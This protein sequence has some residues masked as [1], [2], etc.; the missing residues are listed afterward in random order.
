MFTTASLCMCTI[1]ASYVLQVLVTAACM[2]LLPIFFMSL[3]L[4]VVTDTVSQIIPTNGSWFSSSWTETHIR[5]FVLI[6]FYFS[7]FSL[8]M[9]KK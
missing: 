2:F 1:G 9:F 8:V 6:G 3:C 5:T 7:Y 4:S